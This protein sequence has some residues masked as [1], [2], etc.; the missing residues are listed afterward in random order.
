[1][2]HAGPVPDPRGDAGEVPRGQAGGGDEAPQRSRGR[3][4]DPVG[5][6]GACRAVFD[7]VPD[8]GGKAF[9]RGGHEP[10]GLDGL[11]CEGKRAQRFVGRYRDMQ[12][13]ALPEHGPEAEVLQIAEVHHAAHVSRRRPFF[14]DVLDGVLQLQE[15]GST[16]KFPRPWGAEAA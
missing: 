13:L 3:G 9:V 14:P 12:Q 6:G 8:G 5:R 11:K 7:P 1:M 4:G 10:G 16:R 2:E 15:K